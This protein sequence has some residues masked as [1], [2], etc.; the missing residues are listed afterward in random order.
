METVGGVWLV[1]RDSW[2]YCLVTHQLEKG[3]RGQVPPPLFTE[4][5][6]EARVGRWRAQGLT[7]RCPAFL[8]LPKGKR[9]IKDPLYQ[10]KDWG[11][12]EAAL[13]S[14][15]WSCHRLRWESGQDR[16]LR[17]R[18]ARVKTKLALGANKS[19]SRAST[20]WGQSDTKN[21]WEWLRVSGAKQVVFKLIK[22]S[23]SSIKRTQYLDSLKVP[24][25]WGGP[26]IWPVSFSL[27]LPWP[28]QMQHKAHIHV[29]YSLSPGLSSGCSPPRMLFPLL[30]P[31]SGLTKFYVSF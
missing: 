12:T 6:P 14:W 22:S 25:C 21:I 9:S 2:G 15:N 23:R 7:S 1:D 13:A 4:V 28:K 17:N 29:W 27:V 3:P 10:G 30:T 19:K 31:F 11:V 26:R 20:R 24:H 8:S 18:E 5:D 16:F